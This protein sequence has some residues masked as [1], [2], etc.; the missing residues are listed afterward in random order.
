M[1][2]DKQTYLWPL[3]QEL[4]KMWP[5]NRTVNLVFHGHSI[6]AGYAAGNV[7]RPFDAYPHLVHEILQQRFPGAVINCIVTAIGGENALSGAQR[8]R[9]E[10]LCHRPDL[11]AIDYATNDRFAPREQVEAS[12]RSMLEQ[13]A[14]AGVPVL[15]VTPL[16]DCCR[17]YYD[18]A[19]LVTPF[20][21]LQD[22]IRRLADEYAVGL[23]DASAAFENRVR[24]G[25]QASDFLISVNHPN[26]RGHMLVADELMRWFPF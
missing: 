13:A 9:A 12:W 25:A 22:M 18:P 21:W 14:E 16:P 8:F 15:L 6:P 11:V 1:T 3:A 2:A 7:V 23:A 19:Q 5:G 24:V 4:A 10:A 17:A 20:P 26:R